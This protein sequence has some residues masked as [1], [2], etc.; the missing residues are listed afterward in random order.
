MDNI[1]DMDT[2]RSPDKTALGT[3][4]LVCTPS[5][6]QK[7]NALCFAHHRKIFEGT[8]ALP[9]KL[10]VSHI[11]EKVGL[12]VADIHQCLHGNDTLS[13]WHMGVATMPSQP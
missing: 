2:L 3:H 6:V 5:A 12:S 13:M 1:S 11:V 10:H 7:L 8:Q 4:A 9:V